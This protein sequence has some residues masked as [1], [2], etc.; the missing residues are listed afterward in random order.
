MYPAASLNARAL[1]VRTATIDSARAAV[2]LVVTFV[3]G[4]KVADAFDVDDCE[5]ECAMTG[6]VVEENARP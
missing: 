3:G 1:F 6:V 2:A 4:V 5:A